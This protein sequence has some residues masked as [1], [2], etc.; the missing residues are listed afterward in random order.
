VSDLDDLCDGK[1]RRVY[2]Q[3]G[4]LIPG[5]LMHKLIVAIIVAIITIGGYMVLWAIADAEF[6]ATILHRLSQVEN[7]VQI[8]DR[9]RAGADRQGQDIENMKEWQRD[10]KRKH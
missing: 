10:H 8:H 6:K 1:T 9:Y 5:A 2:D 7:L 3:H 4:Y